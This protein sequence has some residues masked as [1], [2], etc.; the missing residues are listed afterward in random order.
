M[1]SYQIR[2]LDKDGHLVSERH[3]EAHDCTAAMRQL[4]EVSRDAQRI[5]IYN[6][7]GERAGEIS[8]GY[9]RRKMHR[10]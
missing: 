6:E 3:V 7:Q 10:R 2:Q 1:S 4:K 5:E 9:W 8:V